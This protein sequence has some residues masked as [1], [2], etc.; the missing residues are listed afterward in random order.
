MAII[1]ECRS[2]EKSI[3]DAEARRS[4]AHSGDTPSC[5]AAASPLGDNCDSPPGRIASVSKHQGSGRSRR[6]WRSDQLRD[7]R[8]V[9]LPCRS[10]QAN[11][12]RLGLGVPFAAW[13]PT[14][15]ARTTEETARLATDWRANARTAYNSVPVASGCLYSTMEVSRSLSRMVNACA[16]EAETALDP[17]YCDSVRT[18]RGQILFKTWPTH[19]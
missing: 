7:A 4:V 15:E 16:R 18:F 13:G 11:C 3:L 8:E 17:P 6:L 9:G 5:D 1:V 12:C 10:F 19:R 14:I 2:D